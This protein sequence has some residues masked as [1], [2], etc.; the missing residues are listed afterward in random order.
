MLSGRVERE[1]HY[2]TWHRIFALNHHS[3]LPLTLEE[4]VSIFSYQGCTFLVVYF[5]YFKYLNNYL[6]HFS[7]QNTSTLILYRLIPISSRFC[8]TILEI[9]FYWK[10]MY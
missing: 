4:E 10:I 3:I 6:W 7:E 9:Q 8:H 1:K 5:T 2:K